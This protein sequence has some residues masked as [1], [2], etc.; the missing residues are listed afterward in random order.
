MA[1][2]TLNHI[3]R[4]SSVTQGC[5][6]DEDRPSLSSTT[7]PEFK[8]HLPEAEDG[9]QTSFCGGRGSKVKLFTTES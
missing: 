1:A 2:C 8:N 5:H 4:L 6:A 3:F 7:L 9:Y